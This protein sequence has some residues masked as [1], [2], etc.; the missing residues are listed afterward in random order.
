M[1]GTDTHAWA[2][3]S[4]V[5][6]ALFSVQLGLMIEASAH[7]P[8]PSFMAGSSG[9]CVASYVYLAA[10]GTE[11]GIERIS[12]KLNSTLLTTT[13]FPSYLNFLPSWIVGAFKGSIYKKGIGTVP[14]MRNIF[15]TY[16]ITRIEILT[17]TTERVSGKCQI[18]SNVRDDTSVLRNIPFDHT[19]NNCLPVIY[20]DGDITEIARA[21]TASASVPI[22][23]PDEDIDGK[24]YMDGG[25]TYSSPL[26]PLAETLDYIGTRR[27]LH[28]VYFNCYDIESNLSDGKYYNI[29]QNT[30][31][32]L[33]R[34][35]KSLS[36]Q[37]RLRGVDYVKKVVYRTRCKLLYFEGRCGS[38]TLRQ[39][40]AAQHVCARSFLE[41]YTTQTFNIEITDFKYTEILNTIKSVRTDYSFRFWCAAKS[42]NVDTVNKHLSEYKERHE[43]S[44]V[45]VAANPATD[46][47]A[48]NIAN[49]GDI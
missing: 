21:C 25:T 46:A 48:P 29:I 40:C 19:I 4:P 27:P 18:F 38:S 12:R 10:D 24:D 49:L 3:I 35:I 47:T 1:S 37:D 7:L 43:R 9:G 11:E 45:N 42:S 41:L 16:N 13:W 39:I 34:V 17:G 2:Y 22:I 26:T 6:G 20:N 15:S 32:T 8:Q 30:D 14:L 36:V 28:L 31:S 5:S 23:V 44:T 33:S